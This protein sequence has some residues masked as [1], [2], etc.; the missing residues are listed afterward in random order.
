VRRQLS[1][2]AR[3]TLDAA[4]EFGWEHV[5]GKV[6][7]NNNSVSQVQILRSAAAGIAV[8]TRPWGSRK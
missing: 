4:R 5:F 6:E 2:I 7:S 1:K 3:N 8:P